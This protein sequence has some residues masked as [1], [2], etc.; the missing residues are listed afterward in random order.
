MDRVCVHTERS[1]QTATI[2]LQ[3]FCVTPP[4]LTTKE[5][6]LYCTAGLSQCLKHSG[7]QQEM[8]SFTTYMI[9]SKSKCLCV[10]R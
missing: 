1:K 3:D 8:H 2:P 9:S 5:T 10:D 6:E 7:I 4:F